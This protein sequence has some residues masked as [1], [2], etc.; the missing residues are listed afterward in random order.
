MEVYR[1]PKEVEAWKRN[2]GM[3][4]VWRDTTK[5]ADGPVEPGHQCRGEIGLFS[6]SLT[7]TQM[8]R[9]EHAVVPAGSTPTHQ[10]KNTEFLVT[11][12]Q[13]STWG[14]KDL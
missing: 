11:V 9:R 3:A 1:S 10:G 8:P 6:S 4:E 5:R 7:S 14:D 13:T 2:Q 12:F